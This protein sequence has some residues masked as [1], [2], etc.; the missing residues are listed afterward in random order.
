MKTFG[1]LLIALLVT[2]VIGIIAGPNIDNTPPAFQI[3]FLLLLFATMTAPLW[4][5]IAAERRDAVF[6][7][8]VCFGM[9]GIAWFLINGVFYR[10]I[11]QDIAKQIR[12][13]LTILE[14]AFVSISMFSKKK[15]IH[16][17]PQGQ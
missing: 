2:L 14:V 3:I 4:H 13:S 6:L 15:Q 5:K 7:I 12:D 1:Q 8:G 16:S 9:A 10:Y 11:S 17:T